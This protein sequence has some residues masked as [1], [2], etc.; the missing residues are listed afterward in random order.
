[1]AMASIKGDPP[2]PPPGALGQ[3]VAPDEL[4][5]Y[6]DAVT[7]WHE[8]LGR[9][10]A[11]LDERARVATVADAITA[12]VVLASA[13]WESLRTRIEELV[14]TWDS[15]RVGVDE[16]ERIS[17]LI[18]GR[19]GNG[20]DAVMAVSFAE[21]CVLAEA[22]IDRLNDKLEADALGAEGVGDRIGPLREQLARCRAL[23]PEERHTATL[24]A[25]ADE[26]ELLVEQASSG[27]DPRQALAA[28]VERLSRLERDLVVD[29]AGRTSVVR[30]QARLAGR[31]EAAEALEAGVRV[32]AAR[33]L[34]RIA[35]APRLG[36]PDVSVL[37]AVPVMEGDDWRSAAAA[38][39]EL[40]VSVGRLERALHEARARYDAPLARRAELRGMLDAYRSKAARHGRGEDPVLSQAYADA[41]EV[42]YAAPLDLDAGASALARYEALVRAGERRD[43]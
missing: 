29:G 19:L 21:A 2:P 42:L 6:L 38:L 35:G 3:A 25:A 17:Q 26:L 41:R 37:S 27:G 12:D 39:D 40:D 4:L 5:A 11:S 7:R 16:R 13:L 14:T 28:L 23:D 43:A 34:D 8:R 24:D 18:W 9:T 22:M 30:H 31:L 32:L 20:A 1:M 33:C 36:I 10:L 15:G